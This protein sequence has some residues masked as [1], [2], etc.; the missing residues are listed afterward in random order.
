MFKRQLATDFNRRLVGDFKKTFPRP[1]QPLRDFSFFLVANQ[2]QTGCRVGVSTPLIL[3][4]TCNPSRIQPDPPNIIYSVVSVSYM[5]H[6]TSKMDIK[7][8]EIP[9]FLKL[10][11]KWRF[12]AVRVVV[13]YLHYVSKLKLAFLC[14]FETF[15]F[16]LKTL[17]K[18]SSLEPVDRFPGSLVFSIWGLNVC[19]TSVT[20]GKVGPVRLV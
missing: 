10:I 15:P 14:H 13:E 12:V 5:N 3:P 9:R 19:T 6:R 1:L 8:H 2:L 18:F 20:E 17:R 11:N 4:H 16:M 7:F